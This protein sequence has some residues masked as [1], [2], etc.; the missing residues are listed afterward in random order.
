MRLEGITNLKLQIQAGELM[1]A[2]RDQ[3]DQGELDCTSA[4]RKILLS[5]VVGTLS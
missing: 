4:D 1:I 5:Y 3:D 2:I